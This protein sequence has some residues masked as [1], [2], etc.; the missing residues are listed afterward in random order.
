[1][2]GFD[3]YL[4]EK[5]GKTECIKWLFVCG[6][7]GKYFLTDENSEPFYFECNNETVKVMYD[8]REIRSCD[9]ENTLLGYKYRLTE[10]GKWGFMSMGFIQFIYPVY[11]DIIPIE[12]EE[13]FAV[14]AYQSENGKVSVNISK[15]VY[16][17]NMIREHRLV[18]IDVMYD[19]ET[20]PL[21]FRYLPEEEFTPT[22]RAAIE[23]DY[24]KNTGI[25]LYRADKDKPVAAL[26]YRSPDGRKT[27]ML[28][29][30]GKEIEVKDSLGN[31]K[32]V[33]TPDFGFDSCCA[34]LN[35]E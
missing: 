28:Y 10:N 16:L 26:N 33:S 13:G 7:E 1:M 5:S 29:W 30:N 8:V 18:E 2:P 27:S 20:P 11:D 25:T 24:L 9:K 15:S 6:E 21:C 14:V 3:K 23:Y 22:E 4:K 12:C 19:E 31:V 32:R 34:V 35:A 17:G